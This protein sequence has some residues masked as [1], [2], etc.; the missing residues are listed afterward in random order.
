MTVEARF[1]RV[2]LCDTSGNF[3]KA[4]RKTET[5][6]GAAG[7]L[8][9]GSTNRVYTLATTDININIVEVFQDGLLLVR[10][11]M[12]TTNDA[13]KKVTILNPVF[14]AQTITVAYYV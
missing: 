9:D 5:L 8:T 7:T 13:Q 12:Y 2:I 4:T 10:T 6:S 3:I 11:T 14:D 1:R